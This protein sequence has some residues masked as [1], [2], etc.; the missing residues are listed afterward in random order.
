V[1]GNFYKL[2]CFLLIIF[3]LIVCITFYYSVVTFV[4]CMHLQDFATEKIHL[5]ICNETFTRRPVTKGGFP[6]NVLDIT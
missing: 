6:E 5:E 4:D 1:L 3:H 2:N